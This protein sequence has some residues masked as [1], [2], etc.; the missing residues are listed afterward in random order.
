MDNGQSEER[1]SDSPIAFEPGQ[2]NNIY[3]KDKI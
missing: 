3:F 2:H 1:N